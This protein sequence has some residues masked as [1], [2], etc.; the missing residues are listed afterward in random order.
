MLAIFLFC[1]LLTNHPAM[2]PKKNTIAIVQFISYENPLKQ[3]CRQGQD[4]VCIS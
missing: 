1:H 3:E 2:Y 4:F